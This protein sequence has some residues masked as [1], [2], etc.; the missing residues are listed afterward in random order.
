MELLPKNNRDKIQGTIG[1]V[2]LLYLIRQI[3][4]K[5]CLRSHLGFRSS[6]H[7]FLQ[8]RIEMDLQESQVRISNLVLNFL[9]FFILS[10]ILSL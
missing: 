9:L 1:I 7:T 4:F 8:I 5:F 3:C 2:F 6:F 10:L